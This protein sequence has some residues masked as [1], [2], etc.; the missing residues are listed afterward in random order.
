MRGDIATMPS[1]V[2]VGSALRQD[3]LSA[4]AADYRHR[5]A[6][7]R[8][9]IEEGTYA[10]F[11]ACVFRV[12]ALM[13]FDV[14]MDRLGDDLYREGLRIINSG[15]EHRRWC[16]KQDDHGNGC[17]TTVELVMEIV[18]PNPIDVE[19]IFNRMGSLY[20]FIYDQLSVDRRSTPLRIDGRFGERYT[21]YRA[22]PPS[23]TVRF[24]WSQWT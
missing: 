3:Y 24:L 7:T 19:G 2:R 21:A 23:V 5:P 20:G 9:V 6:H 15:H 22:Q 18:T 17:V 10:D 4:L 13:A 11:K 1:G 12:C 14:M 8:P 16:F